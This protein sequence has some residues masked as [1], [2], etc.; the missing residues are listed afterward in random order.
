MFHVNID[1]LNISFSFR[2]IRNAYFEVSPNRVVSDVTVCDLLVN[3]AEFEGL[4]CCVAGDAF[5]KETGRKHALARALE[6]AKLSKEIR[7]QIWED[8]FG[9]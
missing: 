8:Y 6:A 5:R 1:D 9:R 3:G 4:A 7:R 2:H